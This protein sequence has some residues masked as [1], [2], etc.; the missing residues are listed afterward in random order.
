MSQP[1]IVSGIVTQWHAALF[2]DLAVVLC[3]LFAKEGSAIEGSEMNAI[4]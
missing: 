1:K 4:S 3:P 2:H